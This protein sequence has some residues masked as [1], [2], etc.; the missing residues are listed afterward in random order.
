MHYVSPYIEC[1]QAIQICQAV[2]R[3]EMS[4]TDALSSLQSRMRDYTS[5]DGEQASLAQFVAQ[6]TDVALFSLKA[7]DAEIGWSGDRVFRVL[8]EAK[9]T[10]LFLKVF[11]LE[12]KNFIAEIFGIDFL[13]NVS[14]ITSPTLQAIGKFYEEEQ[15]R[16]VIAE[17]PAPGISFQQR[18]NAVA[19]HPECSEERS[20]AFKLLCQA[21]RASAKGLANLHAIR[22][23]EQLYPVAIK[24]FI[25]A[26]LA[27]ACRKIPEEFPV[28][29]LQEYAAVALGKLDSLRF[30]PAVTHGDVKLIH[31]FYDDKTE[32]F[33]LIDPTHLAESLNSLGEPR[34]IALKDYYHFLNSLS[35]NRI[36]YTLDED[37]SIIR[38]EM[39]TKIE[40][41]DLLSVFKISYKENG[42][43][44]PT[45]DEEIIFSLN[46]NLNFIARYRNEPCKFAE[47]V[48]TRLK[49]LSDICIES[50]RQLLL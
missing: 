26:D 40:M 11:S 6:A 47:P 12:S 31:A 42:G 48:P 20:T 24:E 49:E 27:K 50:L 17:T 16:F 19:M 35:L 37:K 33:G 5:R 13:N 14:G 15:L 2:H 23:E 43:I 25:M 45:E 22:G 39:L 36:E 18:Y 9:E 4:K 29:K 7:V 32:Q 1:H 46:Y 44:L 10:Q 28:C 3:N 41:Q 30:F 34:G 38:K 21:V 8:D